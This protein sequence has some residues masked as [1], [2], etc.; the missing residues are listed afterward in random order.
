MKFSFLAA[1]SGCLQSY[2]ETS[3][4]THVCSEHKNP[5]VAIADAAFRCF[6]IHDIL[7]TIKIQVAIPKESY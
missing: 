1:F 3:P 7:I 2:D 5:Q 4:H 6:F